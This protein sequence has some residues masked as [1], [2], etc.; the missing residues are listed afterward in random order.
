M[1]DTSAN[2]YIQQLTSADRR[3]AW[4][5]WCSCLSGGSTCYKGNSHLKPMLQIIDNNG[6]WRGWV[7]AEATFYPG[8]SGYRGGDVLGV[9]EIGSVM[10]SAEK[11][12]ELNR[13][14]AENRSNL[15][16]V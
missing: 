7:G 13:L 2:Y 1:G 12:L 10:G 5:H 3:D 11:D 14:R 9:F 4:W 15:E 6:H 16:L 8:G